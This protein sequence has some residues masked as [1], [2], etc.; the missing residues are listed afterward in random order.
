M[1]TEEGREIATVAVAGPHERS[2]FCLVCHQPVRPGPHMHVTTRDWE[3]CG[4]CSEGCALSY[5]RS[6]NADPPTPPE[7]RTG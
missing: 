1:T 5:L 7:Q 6:V 2:I 3:T 4:Y